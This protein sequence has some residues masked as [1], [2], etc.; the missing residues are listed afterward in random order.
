MQTMHVNDAQ[1]SF[2]S[3]PPSYSTMDDT[4][5]TAKKQNTFRTQY[6]RH[7]HTGKLSDDKRV[8]RD[9]ANF[10]ATAQSPFRKKVAFV[11]H[12]T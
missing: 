8:H 11:Q 7:T 2:R 3:T 1:E 10:N 6:I 4:K 12:Q 9:S 5:E